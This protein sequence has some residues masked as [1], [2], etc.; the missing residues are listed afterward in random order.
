[1]WKT[2][3]NAAGHQ[4]DKVEAIREVVTHAIHLVA[5]EQEAGHAAEALQL[6]EQCEACR[7]G[8]SKASAPPQALLW[9]LR[10]EA[11]IVEVVQRRGAGS[12]LIAELQ[13]ELGAVL[14]QLAAQRSEL[15][16]DNASHGSD[17]SVQPNEHHPPSRRRW[18]RNE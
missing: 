13:C 16:K 5:L 3:T 17:E 7:A 8:D 14:L 12:A 11:F 15:S 18:D 9:H 6:V 10:A 4:H 2:D 1:M